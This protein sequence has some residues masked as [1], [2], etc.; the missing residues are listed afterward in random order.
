MSVEHFVKA[1][2]DSGTGFVSRLAPS[3]AIGVASA[4]LAVWGGTIHSQD[5]IATLQTTQAHHAQLIESMSSNSAAQGQQIQ[6][7]SRKVDHVQETLDKMMLQR[8]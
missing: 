1:V 2:A 6:D 8:R 7:V 4:G 3:L 5:A